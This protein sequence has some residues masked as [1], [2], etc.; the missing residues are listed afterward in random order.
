VRATLPAFRIDGE[1][2]AVPHLGWWSPAAEAAGLRGA[3]MV[4]APRIALSATPF[5]ATADVV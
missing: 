4:F 2:V 5:A 1:P 3:T